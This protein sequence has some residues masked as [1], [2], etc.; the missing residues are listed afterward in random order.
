MR[1]STLTKNG[2]PSKLRGVGEKINTLDVSTGLGEDSYARFEPRE[3]CYPEKN[4][5]YSVNRLCSSVKIIKCHR[6]PEI[7]APSSICIC[8]PL[9]KN[10]C[11]LLSGV[12]IFAKLEFLLLRY[13]IDVISVYILM[14]WWVDVSKVLQFI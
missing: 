8:N 4:H 12:M 6:N 10:T 5:V 11:S 7:F 14:C 1:H 9:K 2:L 3:T 13:E